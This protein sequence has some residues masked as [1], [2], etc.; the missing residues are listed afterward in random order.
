[1]FQLASWTDLFAPE[2]T[3]ANK[4]NKS[5]PITSNQIKLSRIKSNQASKETNI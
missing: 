1:V 3:Q 2:A 4:Q 5:N